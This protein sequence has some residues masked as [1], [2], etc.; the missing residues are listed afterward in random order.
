[1]TASPSTSSAVFHALPVS[2][3]SRSSQRERTGVFGQR[4]LVD[5][6]HAQARVEDVLGFAEGALDRIEAVGVSG[7]GREQRTQQTA[8]LRNSRRVLIVI[9]NSQMLLLGSTVPRAVLVLFQK[10]Q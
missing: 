7:A 6:L 1:M 8:I 10:A 9:E 4:I 3:P 5:V 2:N